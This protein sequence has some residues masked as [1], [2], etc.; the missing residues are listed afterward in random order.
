MQRW[1]MCEA[2]FLLG[3]FTDFGGWELR[4]KW[5][6]GMWHHSPYKLP[7]WDGKSAGRVYVI[8]EQGLGTRFSSMR[9]FLLT[10]WWSVTRG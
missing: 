2:R 3:D 7:M 1:R 10:V 8:G 5:A 4:D 9:S 6:A